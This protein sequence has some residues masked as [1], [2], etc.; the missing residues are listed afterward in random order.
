MILVIQTQDSENYAAHD[1]DGQGVCPQYWKFKGGQCIKITGLTADA[2]CDSVVDCVREK[3][4][5]RSV[6]F[7]SLIV[8]YGLE[9]DGW[10]S[11][12]ETSQL[13]YDGSITYPEPSYS[14]DAI[15]EEI[16]GPAY[17]EVEADES[18]DAD[19]VYYGA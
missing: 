8:G 6:Y 14:W 18:Y 3:I 12:F 17:A 16:M 13:E 1:W 2:D 15:V 11:E 10:M 19:A 7:R 4:E 9:A 5:V